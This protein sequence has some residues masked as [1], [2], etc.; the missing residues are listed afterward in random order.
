MKLKT[1]TL[2]LSCLSFHGLYAGTAGPSVDKD[3]VVCSSLLC[4]F[5]SLGGLYLSGTGYYVLPS[6]TGLG[7]VTDSWLFNTPGGTTARSLPVNPHYKWAGGF[8]VGYDL[9]M[10]ANNI[11]F[12]Y[13]RL[14]NQTRAV[15][16]FSNG[17][18]LFSGILFP[19]AI[20]PPGLIA[21]FVSDATLNYTV[22]QYDLKVGRKYSETSGVFQVKPSLGVR[23]AE[24]THN[25]TFIQPGQMIS[26]FRG[27]GP[28]FSLDTHYFLGHGFGLLGYFD[29]S[30]MSGNIC[31]DS[32]V[33]LGQR[34]GFSWP[35]RNRVVNNVI[36]KIGVDYSHALT[37]SATWTVAVGYQVNEYFSSMDTIR[38]VV[39][40]PG[41]GSPLGGQ[42]V[43]GYETNNFSFQG[44]FV[45]L[46][47]HA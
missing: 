41:G 17:S 37:N 7:L 25:F 46:S 43:F 21:N 44:L 2:A 8:S 14:N 19:D 15:N 47:A 9:P 38:G 1:L 10:S 33:V 26:N 35:K 4:A 40:V 11:E 31:A 5:N 18:I 22:N 27:T 34:Y 32:F 16:S 20:I 23:Y 36:G 45:T 39:N 42:R 13:L 12:N 3:G 30:L 6:E 29:Y 28:L 24:I